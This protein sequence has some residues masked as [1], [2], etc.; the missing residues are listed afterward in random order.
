MEKYTRHYFSNKCFMHVIKCTTDYCTFDSYMHHFQV[1]SAA[2]NFFH[3]KNPFSRYK[4]YIWCLLLHKPYIIN[5]DPLF[6]ITASCKHG[7]YSIS[8]ERP[9]LLSYV[10]VT[11]ESETKLSIILTMA[12][13][14]KKNSGPKMYPCPGTPG[15]TSWGCDLVPLANTSCSHSDL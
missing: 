4:T 8:R 14:T 10:S 7:L 15:N 12:Q 11:A 3:Y 9:L 13:H 6:Y 5:C 2:V 1:F